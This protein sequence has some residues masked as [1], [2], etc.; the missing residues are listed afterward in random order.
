MLDE[1]ITWKDHPQTIEKRSLKLLVFIR[2]RQLF[3]NESLRVLRLFIS[4]IS[5]PT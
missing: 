2:A 5:I 3:D 1:H 4:H